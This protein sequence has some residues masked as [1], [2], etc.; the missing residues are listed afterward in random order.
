MF[1]TNEEKSIEML[2]LTAK[3]QTF[4]GRCYMESGLISEASKKLNEA[5]NSLDYNFPQRKFMIDLKSTIQLEQLRWRLVC[6]KHWKIDTADELTTN[7]IEQLANCLALMFNV[8]RVRI[9]I[10]QCVFDTDV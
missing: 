9:I 1:E 3:I 2:Y 7:Y 4:Q 10:L 8:F 6:P 5:M